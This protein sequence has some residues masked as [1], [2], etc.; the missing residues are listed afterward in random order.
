MVHCLWLVD[1]T[2]E[3]LCTW[4]TEPL[5]E[6]RRTRDRLFRKQQVEGSNPP[7]GFIDGHW[8][9]VAAFFVHGRTLAATSSR[10]LDSF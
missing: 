4:S 9:V 2:R 7:V 10:L 5:S 8:Y 3:H 1:K 6:L